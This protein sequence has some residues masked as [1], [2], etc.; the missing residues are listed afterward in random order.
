MNW[1]G[2]GKDLAAVA[3]LA[4]LSMLAGMTLNR[5]GSNPRPLV[6]KSPGARLQAEL[7]QLFTAPPFDSFHVA[8]IDLGEFRHVVESKSALIFDA[9]SPVFYRQG[10]VP[11]A[12]NLSRDQ[13]GKDYLRLQSTLK[14]AKDRPIVVYC[15]GGSCHDSKMVAQALTSLGFSQVRI[16]AGG[17]D[18]WTAAQMPADK[19]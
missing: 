14:N 9:R 6:Y 10:H 3:G 12:L 16:F 11:G 4:M 1:R 13:F 8:T 18:A 15:S 5:F 17:W 7:T 19:G 2:V